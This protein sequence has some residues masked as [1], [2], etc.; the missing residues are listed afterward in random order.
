MVV[1]LAFPTG[2]PEAG[3]QGVGLPQPCSAPSC[4]VGHR[5]HAGFA[6]RLAEQKKELAETGTVRANYRV[7]RL[8]FRGGNMVSMLLEMT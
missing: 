1:S 3:A 4:A 8:G 2:V 7:C 5:A 6:G